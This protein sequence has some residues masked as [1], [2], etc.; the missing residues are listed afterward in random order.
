M[1]FTERLKALLSQATPGPWDSPLKDLGAI[2]SFKAVDFYFDHSF[3]AY[4]PL[5]HAGPLFVASD[6]ENAELIVYLRNHAPALLRVVIEAER[7]CVNLGLHDEHEL[8]DSLRA[9]SG[10]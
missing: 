7:A 3:E 1:N 9:L 8:R 4:P 6:K 10:E 5:G 2:E